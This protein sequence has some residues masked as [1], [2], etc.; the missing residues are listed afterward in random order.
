MFTK[1]AALTALFVTL[2]AASPLPG[3]GSAA[4]CT[5]G[6]IQCCNTISE[7]SDHSSQ[8][9]LALLGIPIQD[10]NGQL[11]IQCNPIN[12][13][14]AGQGAD[15]SAHPVCCDETRQVNGF[16]S[17]VGINCVPISLD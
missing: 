4:T 12:V 13:I 17:L 15:C 8:N 3:A 10:V 16:D 6:D 11:G 1:L 9:L 7:T 2:A 5:T 14:G